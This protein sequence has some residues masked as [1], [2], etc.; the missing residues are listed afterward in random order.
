MDV[1]AILGEYE[2]KETLQVPTEGR[3][4]AILIKDFDTQEASSNLLFSGK[5]CYMFCNS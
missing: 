4:L 1:S 2:L 5:L 3:N